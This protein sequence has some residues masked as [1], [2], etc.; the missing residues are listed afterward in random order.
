[1]LLTLSSPGTHRFAP[2]RKLFDVAHIAAAHEEHKHIKIRGRIGVHSELLERQSVVAVR[3]ASNGA[4]VGLLKATLAAER[5]LYVLLTERRE[6]DALHPTK[7]GGQ[8]L[9]GLVA[10]EDE[11]RAPDR[12]FERF[13]EFVGAGEVHLVGLPYDDDFIAAGFLCHKTE[14]LYDFCALTFVDFR[15]LI[16]DAEAVVPCVAT[17]PGRFREQCAPFRDKG[18]ADGFGGGALFENGE[19]EMEVGV[20]E[21]GRHGAVVAMSA[22]RKS[23]ALLAEQRRGKSQCHGKFS[24]SRRAAEELCV[25]HAPFLQLAE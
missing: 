23:L 12:F 7:D 10:H 20:R 3:A 11:G 9:L 24:A 13:E 14:F 18:V 2:A 8:E 21:V 16:F 6:V 22:R 15:L 4:R 17:D 5:L 1:M 19:D 25:R